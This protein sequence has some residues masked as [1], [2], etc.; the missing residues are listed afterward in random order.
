MLLLVMALVFFISYKVVDTLLHHPRDTNVSYELNMDKT[1]YEEVEFKSLK[2]DNTIRGSF[3]PA[4]GLPG[5][6]SNKTIIVVHGYT[7]N[8]LVKGRTQ[9]L[10]EHFVPKGYNVLAFDLSSQGKSDGDLITLGL[11][12]KIRFARS[13]K[14][15]KIERPYG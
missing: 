14:L 3:F 10:V 1:P 9:K 8:R 4:S 11:N 7:S 12:E 5:K 15:F 6:S 2:N 13:C